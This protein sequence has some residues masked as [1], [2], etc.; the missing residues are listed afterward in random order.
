MM[1]SINYCLIGGSIIAS[2]YHGYRWSLDC[3]SMYV[4]KKKNGF[5]IIGIRGRRK[6][7]DKIFFPIADIFSDAPNS[8]KGCYLF[9]LELII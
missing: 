4:C 5:S 9:R 8:Q 1:L 2:Q 6:S 7:T 3:T